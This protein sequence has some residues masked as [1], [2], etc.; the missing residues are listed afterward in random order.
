MH[1]ETTA[2]ALARAA[3]DRG[4][5]GLEEKLTAAL[6]DAVAA[7]R[8]AGYPRAEILIVQEPSCEEGIPSGWCI[9]AD[10]EDV[11]IDCAL[12]CMAPIEEHFP[13]VAGDLERG[14]RARFWIEA[15]GG[16]TEAPEGARVD[17]CQHWISRVF[18]RLCKDAG[19]Y[20]G[21]RVFWAVEPV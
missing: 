5:V 20:D 8:R 15:A 19:I 10:P 2:R 3:V 4:M 17:I 13:A 12:F 7:G 9:P 18:R 21:E 1:A 11:D 6:L 16:R 14:H